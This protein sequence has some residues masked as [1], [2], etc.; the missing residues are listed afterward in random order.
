LTVAVAVAAQGQGAAAS[1]LQ[2][3]IAIRLAQT[4]N[5]QA[6]AVGLLGVLA[7]HQHGLDEF[8]GGQRNSKIVEKREGI[9]DVR[10]FNLSLPSF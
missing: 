10:Y 3:G 4:Q 1:R 2:T 9:Y 7:G 5:P 8:F 6:G